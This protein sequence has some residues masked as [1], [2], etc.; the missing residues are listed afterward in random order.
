MRNILDIYKEYKIMS[1]LQEHQFRVAAVGA[2]ICNS[3][4][5]SVRREAVVEACL[6]HDMGNI[7]KFELGYF[8]E[9]LEPEGIAYWKEVQEMYFKKYGRNEHEAT[10][11]IAA[12]LGVSQ[13]ILELIDSFGYTKVCS[14][15]EVSEF[16]KK[17]CCYADMRVGPY[18]VVSIEERN[19]D[20]KKRYAND[21]KKLADDKRIAFDTCLSNLEK[22]IFEQ[23][24]IKPEEITDESISSYLVGLRDTLV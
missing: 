4:Q 15:T 20:G 6:L 18:G 17:I 13:E 24:T 10:K 8:P 5:C 19:A 14:N 22:Q 7:I 3:L 23:A 11:L 21:F 9:F 1:N 2:V 16:E 12:E